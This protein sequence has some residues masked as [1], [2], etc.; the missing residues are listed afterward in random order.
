MMHAMPVPRSSYGRPSP[1]AVHQPPPPRTTTEAVL[2]HGGG[3][4]VLAGALFVAF[5]A[6]VFASF[7]TSSCGILTT[8]SKVH[9]YQLFELAIGLGVAAVPAIWA[10]IARAK[11]FNH[12][13]WTITALA[14]TEATLLV[15]LNTTKVAS[16]CF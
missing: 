4:F 13:A 7:V 11:R 2:F 16:F 14:L 9:E 6:W 8:P 15:A 12:L 10:A 1:W 3:V 5:F